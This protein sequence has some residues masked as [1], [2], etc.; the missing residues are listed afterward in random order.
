[1]RYNWLCRLTLA[2]RGASVLLVANRPLLASRS[3]VLFRQF[4]RIRRALRVKVVQ[5]LLPILQQFQARGVLGF[6]AGDGRD[7]GGSFDAIIGSGQPSA[8]LK[9]LR[10]H[11]YPAAILLFG[12]GKPLVRML[13]M[14]LNQQLT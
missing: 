12:F 2:V 6:V 7:R 5:L 11:S 13:T 3:C 10:W 14:N 8:A 4:A 9:R 1:M